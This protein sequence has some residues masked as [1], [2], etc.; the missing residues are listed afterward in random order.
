MSRLNYTTTPWPVIV[1]Y[2]RDD[3]SGSVNHPFAPM[4]VLLEKIALSRYVYGLYGNKSMWDLRIVQTQ[5]YD[6]DGEGLIIKYDP[7]RQEFGFELQ[8]AASALH[9]RWTRKCVA[10]DAF[11]TFEQFLQSK[12]WFIEEKTADP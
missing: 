10:E 7:D 4:L 12:K 9:K 3:V 11:R 8:E 2:Y 1:E 5:E 6:P